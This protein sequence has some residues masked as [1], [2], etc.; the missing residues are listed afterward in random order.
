M[1][2]RL[3]LSL[4]LTLIFISA[5]GGQKPETS[6]PG[7]PADKTETRLVSETE[8]AIPP[9]STD[10]PVPVSQ[11]PEALPPDPQSVN[12]SALDGQPLQGKF[13]PAAVNS[14]PIIVLMH[15]YPGDLE[16]WT[17][18]AFWLQNRG[19]KD[20]K[21]GVP[22]K[23][24]SWFPPLGE[25]QSFNVL[26]FTFRNC[27]GGCSAPDP[28][29]WQLD[30]RASLEFARTLSGV[31]PDRV[32]AIGASI[33]SDGAIVGCAAVLEG[34][35]NACLGALSLS[36]GSYLGI[37]YPDLVTSLGNSDPPRPAWCLYDENDADSAVCTQASGENYYRESWSDG[38][39]HGMHLL[40]PNLAPLP[41]G[42]ILEFLDLVL[43]K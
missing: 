10:T 41:M 3:I 22:W 19:L 27:G 40:T 34:D 11:V 17:E 2:K 14:S 29:G 33:G 8:A 7:Q 35:P 43:D 16:E 23:D 5:C 42:R 6:P 32:I 31:D 1:K 26:T 30:A 28:E 24:P 18:I 38:Y 20:D 25:D 4:L 12:F 13:F 21:N 37:P 15:W 9:K 36:P 39:L